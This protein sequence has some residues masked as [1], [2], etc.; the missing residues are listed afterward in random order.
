[1]TTHPNTTEDLL[2]DRKLDKRTFLR[3]DLPL[4]TPGFYYKLPF[5]DGSEAPETRLAI[6]DL[7]LPGP[8]AEWRPSRRLRPHL[9]RLPPRPRPAP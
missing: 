2:Q 9:A 1:M 3:L 5:R 4:D 7:E 6:T 8:P